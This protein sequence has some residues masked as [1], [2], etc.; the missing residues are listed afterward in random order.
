MI[1]GDSSSDDDGFDPQELAAVQQMQNE[2]DAAAGQFVRNFA[3]NK[4]GM[5][6]KLEEIKL[7]EGTPWIETLDFTTKAPLDIEDAHDDLKREA[8]FYAHSLA[9]ATT[10]ILQL[11]QARIPYLRPPDFF[12]EMV[13]PD[14]QMQ[15]IKDSLLKD[16]I[17][18][19]NSALRQKEKESKKYA[20]AVKSEKMQERSKKK[21]ETMDILKNHQKAGRA[22][23]IVPE[24]SMLGSVEEA[25]QRGRQE[26]KEQG[27]KRQSKKRDRADK[28]YGHGKKNKRLNRND[29]DSSNDMKGF[30]PYKN[31]KGHGVTAKGGRGGGKGGKGGK[32]G[33]KG[34]GRGGGN[35]PG[36]AARAASRK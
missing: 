18:M 34:G 25:L 5:L 26:N 31:S 27:E 7:P 30:N 29:A 23:H 35:R 12:A 9:G 16:K 11:E 2:A 33:G 19:D 28:K 20:Q 3:D 24:T 32:G 22:G 15:R 4:L 10:A 14:S 8:E 13:K 6:S 1:G 36:K 21:R 17:K